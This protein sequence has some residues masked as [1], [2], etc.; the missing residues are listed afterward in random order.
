MYCM[1]DSQFALKGILLTCHCWLY[2]IR[3][4]SNLLFIVLLGVEAY[5]WV[6]IYYCLITFEM[7]YGKRLT[8]TTKMDSVWGMLFDIMTSYIT[9]SC[10]HSDHYNNR[11]CKIL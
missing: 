3:G 10:F 7:T 11:F 4:H 5:Y 6:S 1:S 2:V 9:R 8:S